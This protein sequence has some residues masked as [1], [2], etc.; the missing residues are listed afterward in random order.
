MY[1]DTRPRRLSHLQRL[2]SE[3]DITLA[4]VE[5]AVRIPRLKL[6]SYEV[7]KVHI[8]LYVAVRISQ[9]MNVPLDQLFPEICGATRA[10]R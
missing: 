1:L 6:K 5:R 8:P 10:R 7:G 2:R 4:A 9:Y 3:N